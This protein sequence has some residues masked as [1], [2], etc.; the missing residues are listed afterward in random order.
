MITLPEIPSRIARL[1]RDERGYP[2]PWFVSWIDGKPE[3][4][5]ADGRKF[6]MA[7]KHKLCWV[8]GQRLGNR[9]A[10]VLGPMC[11]VS[12]TTAEPPCHPGCAE[13][14]AKACPFLTKPK[15]VRREAN[16]PE[17]ASE[18]AGFAIKRNPGVT[19]LW[20]TD[21][22]DTFDDGRGGLLFHVGDP[23]EVKWFAEG[24]AAKREEIVASM[25]SGLPILMDMARKEGTQ[26]IEELGRYYE[27]ALTL[28]PA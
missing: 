6:G 21:S 12:R 20:M 15:A 17:D 8:C 24:R 4:R 28:V 5:C 13:F 16:L 11:G 25:E 27:R 22:Y 14:S 7:I 9:M 1:P 26:A 23:K 3:F 10:F 2:V 18:A 19:L